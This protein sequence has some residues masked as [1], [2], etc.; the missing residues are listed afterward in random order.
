M[1]DKQVTDFIETADIEPTDFFHIKR[2]GTLTDYKMSKS[3]MGAFFNGEDYV[4][5]SSPATLSTNIRYN[6][7]SNNTFTFPTI[8][9]LA[10]GASITVT[11]NNFT[12]LYV[13]DGGNGELFEQSGLTDTDYLH[14]VNDTEITF[15]FD[16]SNWRI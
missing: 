15:T 1:A 14:D 9:G 10:V 7:T 16:G 8:I 12:P 13:V 4:T 3:S 5:I 2:P 6:I 11:N